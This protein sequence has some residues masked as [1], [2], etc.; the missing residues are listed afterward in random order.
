MNGSR[1]RGMDYKDFEADGLALAVSRLN[2]NYRSASFFDDELIVETALTEAKSRRF[3]FGYKI[4]RLADEQLIAEAQT[5]HT[6]TNREGRAV[7][8]EGGWLDRLK[9]HQ[10]QL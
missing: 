3:C 6:P 7:R 4:W 1:Q 10:S 8:C 5:F 2:V 9:S